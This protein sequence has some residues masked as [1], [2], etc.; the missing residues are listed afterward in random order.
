MF[1][2]SNILVALNKCKNNHTEWKLGSRAKMLIVHM[3]IKNIL[4]ILPPAA[5]KLASNLTH[6]EQLHWLSKKP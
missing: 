4:T 6:L 3:Y 5:V 2:S 1:R